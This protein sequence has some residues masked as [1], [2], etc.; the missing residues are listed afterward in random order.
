MG[1]ASA[2]EKA[3]VA[4]V[5]GTVGGELVPAQ[6]TAL[7]TTMKRTPAMIKQL[8]ADARG[9]FVGRAQD[10]VNAHFEAMKQ[11]LENKD[12][13]SLAVA[14]KAAEWAIANINGDGSRVVDKANNEPQGQKIF[15]GI[16]MGNMDQK[17]DIEVTEVHDAA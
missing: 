13:K 10:Y 9:T 3:L 4:H 16:K 6:I 14:V 12:P 11:A 15:I 1:K 5:V 17:P 7:A 2:E 8:V